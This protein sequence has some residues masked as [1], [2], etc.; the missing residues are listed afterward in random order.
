MKKYEKPFL[1]IYELKPS[2]ELLIRSGETE[3]TETVEDEEGN[4]WTPIF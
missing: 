1:E 4:T 3:N 2:E